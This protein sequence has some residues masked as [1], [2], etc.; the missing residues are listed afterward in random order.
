MGRL[1]PP[2]MLS[3]R[4]MTRRDGATGKLIPFFQGNILDAKTLDE[5]EAGKHNSLLSSM[6]IEL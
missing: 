3:Q 5:M 4:L 6:G 1:V 2:S